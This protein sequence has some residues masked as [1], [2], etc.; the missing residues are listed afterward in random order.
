[1]AENHN[2][3][4][5]VAVESHYEGHRR[6]IN[7]L[8][9]KA[10]IDAR[11]ASQG[12]G[13]GSS[14]LVASVT[15]TDAQIKALPTTGIQIIASPGAGKFLY[16][17]SAAI[18]HNWVAN[19][20]NIEGA[21]F[22]NITSSIGNYNVLVGIYQSIGSSVSDLLAASESILA[23]C[24]QQNAQL[25]NYADIPLSGVVNN[26]LMI[27]MYNDVGGNLTGGN[28]ANTLKVTVYY[29]VVDL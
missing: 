14:Y 27:N 8:D 4:K 28:A 15:L 21:S 19:Y 7:D 11:I 1:M 20:T 22:I 3:S 23:V 5:Y 10:Y 2:H 16:P 13:G 6:D 26:G 12:G 29:V 18:V 9:L 17:I 24:G 25:A